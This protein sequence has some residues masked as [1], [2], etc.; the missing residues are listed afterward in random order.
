[1]NFTVLESDASRP[2]RRRRDIFV[3]TQIKNIKA[4]SGAAYSDRLPDD[5]A[6]TEL[7]SFLHRNL[8][9]CRTYGAGH[10]VPSERPTI[11]HGFNRGLASHNGIESRRDGRKFVWLVRDFFRPCGACSDLIA[12]PTVKTAGYYLPPLL[13]WSLRV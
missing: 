12:L 3:E 9:I 2:Q 11:A 7:E 13:G 10:K 5:V 6:P 8:Q 4:P 1:M